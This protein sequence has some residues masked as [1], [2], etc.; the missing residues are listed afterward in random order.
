MIVEKGSSQESYETQLEERESIFY[1]PEGYS[2]C[3]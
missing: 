2:I 3:E 1:V